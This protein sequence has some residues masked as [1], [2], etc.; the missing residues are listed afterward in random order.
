[1]GLFISDPALLCLQ[2]RENNK[3]REKDIRSNV[4]E[5]RGCPDPPLLPRLDNRMISQ[6]NRVGILTPYLN[7]FQCWI[8]IKGVISPGSIDIKPR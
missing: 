5:E 7:K 1:L 6:M 8:L 4:M 2:K 3:K